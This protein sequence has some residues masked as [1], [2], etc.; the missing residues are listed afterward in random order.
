M[1]PSISIYISVSRAT[2]RQ[3]THAE[4]SAFDHRRQK[5]QNAKDAEEK[6]KVVR[7]GVAAGLA[8]TEHEGRMGRARQLEGGG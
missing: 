8:Q 3:E 2:R 6:K 5:R 1:S 4:P 7:G